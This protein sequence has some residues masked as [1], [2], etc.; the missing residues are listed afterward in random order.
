[1]KSSWDG[2]FAIFTNATVTSPLSDF[3]V[4][5]FPFLVEDR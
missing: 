4:F 1:M 2:D 5:P 3:S